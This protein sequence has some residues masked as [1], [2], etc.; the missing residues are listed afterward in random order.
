MT[1]NEL[2]SLQSHPWAPFYPNMASAAPTA[3]DIAQFQG[4]YAGITYAAPTAL[5][6][7][8]FWTVKGAPRVLTVKGEKRTLMVVGSPRTLRVDGND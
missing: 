5:T 1:E 3:G 8:P 6:A 2:R 7:S 4:L